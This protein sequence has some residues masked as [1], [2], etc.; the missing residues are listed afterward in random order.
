MSVL[1]GRPGPDRVGAVR[2]V[3][4]EMPVASAASAQSTSCFVTGNRVGGP[5]GLAEVQN[6]GHA[7]LGEHP[8]AGGEEEDC[9][10]HRTAKPLR[11]EC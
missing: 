9:I 10:Y 5:H 8:A 4:E 6:G 1:P 3:A 11:G 7:P 2:R